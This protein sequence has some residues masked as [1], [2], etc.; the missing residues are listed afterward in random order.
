VVALIDISFFLLV[1]FLLVSRMDATAPFSVLPPQA[2][3][4]ADMPGGGITVSI[5]RNGALALDGVALDAAALGAAMTARLAQA[6][7]TLVRINAD[8]G[9][10]LRDVLPLTQAFEAMGARRVVLAVTPEAAP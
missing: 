7:Q 6:P 5:A 4:G 9:A 10:A 3:I 8:R 2:E 1:F